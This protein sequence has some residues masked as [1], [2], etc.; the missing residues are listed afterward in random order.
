MAFSFMSSG[1]CCSRVAAYAGFFE[2]GFV[3]VDVDVDAESPSSDDP[4]DAMTSMATSAT[5][6]P[7]DR[8][9]RPMFSPEQ[10]GRCPVCTG[11]PLSYGHEGTGTPPPNYV[12]T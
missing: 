3:D 4:H 12:E 9:V 6:T 11:L 7:T 8:L 5:A 1:I 2:S 10:S